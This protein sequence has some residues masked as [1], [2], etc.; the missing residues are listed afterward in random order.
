MACAFL[1]WALWL[2]RA[3]KLPLAHEEDGSLAGSLSS[4]SPTLETR[5]APA[6]HPPVSCTYTDNHLLPSAGLTSFICI[7]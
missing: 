3:G 4:L 7:S 6:A 2:G 5:E 1:T